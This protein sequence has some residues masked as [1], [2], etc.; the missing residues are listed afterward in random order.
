MIKHLQ[1]DSDFFGFPIGVINMNNEPEWDSFIPVFKQKASKF[2]LIYFITG[3]ELLLP[4]KFLKDLNG[5]LINQR[6]LYS[7]QIMQADSNCPAYISEHKET[8]VHDD[9]IELAYLSGYYS[10]FKIDTNFPAGKFKELYKTWIR[11][12][13]E[14]SIADRI[15]VASHNGKIKAMVTCKYND[16]LCKIGLVAVSESEQG[17]GTGRYLIQLTEEHAFKKGLIKIQVPTQSNNI[18]ACRFYKK[19]GFSPIRIT[20]YYHFW[21][22]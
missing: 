2:K 22:K 5:R 3:E 13:L 11:R 6:V 4:A 16:S 17:K 21:I 10:R 19:Q 12:S 20:N 9:F 8:K 14:R 1:W 15:F 7:K 18:I